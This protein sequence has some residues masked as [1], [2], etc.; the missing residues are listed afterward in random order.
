MKFKKLKKGAYI[1]EG[2]G[3][4]ARVIDKSYASRNPYGDW[5]AMAWLPEGKIYV[6]GNTRIQAAT[7]LASRLL[8]KNLV[9]SLG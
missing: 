4:E 8:N 1:I 3:V 5:S 2:L 7:D 9:R 6:T